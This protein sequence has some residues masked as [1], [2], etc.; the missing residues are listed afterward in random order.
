LHNLLIEKGAN[1]NEEE[2]YFTDGLRYLKDSYPEFKDTIASKLIEIHRAGLML[3]DINFANVAI[4]DKSRDPIFIDFE[5][6][7]LFKKLNS[8]AFLIQ[9]DRDT[10]K[11]NRLIDSKNYTYKSI[12]L[13]LNELITSGQVYAPYSI[14][15]GLHTPGLYDRNVGFGKYFYSIESEVKQ[16]H[17]KSILS[18]GTNNSCIELMIARKLKCEITSIESDKENVAQAQFFLEASEWAENKDIKLKIILGDMGDPSNLKSNYDLIM[19][20]CSLYYLGQEEM[21]KMLNLIQKTSKF[22][23]LQANNAKEIGREN[24]NEYRIASS[25]WQIKKLNDLGYQIIRVNEWK[26]YS[27]PTILAYCQVK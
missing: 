6:A 5:S 13:K 8:Y 22:I 4:I 16:T 27:R 14:G 9:R 21:I 17:A 19:A 12:R 23:L 10:L 26:N 3:Y 24:S 1:L 2:T 7:R 15:F 25:S 11:L 18:M 20:L